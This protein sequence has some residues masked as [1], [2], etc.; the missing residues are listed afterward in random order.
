M[1][2]KAAES[3]DFAHRQA[4]KSFG[5]L[6]LLRAKEDTRVTTMSTPPPTQLARPSRMK[7][8]EPTPTVL[9]FKDGGNTSGKLQVVSVSGGLLNLPKPATQGSVAKLMF[10]TQKG[11]VLGAAEM[12]QPLSSTLQPFRFVA[13][14]RE[15]HRRLHQSVLAALS[16]ESLPDQCLPEEDW[17]RKYRAAVTQ[18]PKP[19]NKVFKMLFGAITVLT[20]ITGVAY[21]RH[22]HR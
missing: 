9:R 19:E 4:A 14:D 8:A 6:L 10:L 16:K 15:N 18:K 12:L 1:G 21:F 20:M 7:L 22:T 2:S 3:R 17:I 5:N 11:P 13:L